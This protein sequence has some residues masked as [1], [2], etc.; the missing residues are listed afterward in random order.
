MNKWGKSISNKCYCTLI[1]W[2]KEINDLPL[3][4]L[5][6]MFVL[7]ISEFD[8]GDP[9]VRCFWKNRI[10]KQKKMP[11]FD[12]LKLIKIRDSYIENYLIS[13]YTYLRC[14]NHYKDLESENVSKAPVVEYWFLNIFYPL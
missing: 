5:F 13:V 3:Q 12:V 9:H 10:K 4:L 14:C 8:T 2:N 11:T 1:K 6:F 7:T